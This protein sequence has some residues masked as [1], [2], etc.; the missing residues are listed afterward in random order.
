LKQQGGNIKEKKGDGEHKKRTGVAK[1]LPAFLVTILIK[2]SNFIFHFLGLSIKPLALKKNQFGAACLTSL[3]M[4]GFEDATAPF[5]GNDS[6]KFRIHR[7]HSSS[8][9]KCSA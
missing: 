7:M 5:T 6:L 4:M 8:C 1:F 3:G 9:V 2:A